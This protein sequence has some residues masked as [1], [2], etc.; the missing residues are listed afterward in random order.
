MRPIWRLEADGADITAACADRL[1]NLTVTD[2]AGITSDTISISLDNRDL[3]IALPRKG[4][5]LRLWLGYEGGN[6][7][8]MGRYVVDEIE[9]SG[10]PHVLS[11][12]GKAADMRAELKTRKT[13]GWQ[14]IALGDLVRT[15]AAEHGL[16]PVVS[17]DLAG[18]VLPS[19]AQTNESDPNLLTRL[20]RDYD[21]VAKPVDGRLIF[22]PRGEAR[23]A[24]GR[25]M[26]TIA[27][28]AADLNDY[29]VVMADRGQ[30]AVARA[31]WHNAA[32]GQL[33]DVD[34]G[35]GGDGP[36]YTLPRRYPD[37]DQARAAARAKLD[38]VTRGAA[39]FSGTV[40]PGRPELAAE[41]MLQVS[42]LGAGVDGAWVVTSA[43]H[44]LDKG[45][46]YT[47]EVEAEVPK[48]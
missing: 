1:L 10:P 3:A 43:R 5:T 29:R 18:I 28:S 30:Y 41:T 24:S 4:A 12:K 42:G 6:L 44:S 34:I 17:A 27:V 46:G 14:N 22:V 15:I 40:H 26:A 47:T 35:D 33:V 37:A 11:I 19:I 8:A 45:S 23:T 16:A 32:T 13:R 9:R 21:A 38:A 31:R 39:T 25:P 48:S 7:V 36:V 2:E 20:A